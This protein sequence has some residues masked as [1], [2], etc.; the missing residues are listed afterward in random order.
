MAK[1]E[2][3]EQLEPEAQTEPEP[4]PEDED[5]P[6]HEPLEPE[7]EDEPA[8]SSLSEADVEGGLEKIARE[9]QRHADYVAEV[10]GE[11]F[12]T[13]SVCPLCIDFAAGFIFT[14]REL[15]YE[16][17]AAV[18]LALGQEPPPNYRQNAETES[19]ERCGGLGDLLSGSTTERSRI[20]QCPDCGGQGFKYKAAAAAQPV[21]VVPAPPPVVATE[22]FVP[23]G[24]PP[25]PTPIYDY[26]EQKWIIP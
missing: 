14:G 20:M 2:A 22:V 18:M 19:C 25:P 10:M 16:Q 17:Q 6:E 9:N 12:L 13:V 15:P 4:E 8:A 21:A 11:D 5:E 3:A 1:A 24:A 23:P 26:A 7:P